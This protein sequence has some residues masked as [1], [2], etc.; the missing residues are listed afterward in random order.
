MINLEQGAEE[1]EVE[2]KQISIREGKRKI[3]RNVNTELI[4]KIFR[5]LIIDDRD[6][7][8]PYYGP[9]YYRVMARAH[10]TEEYGTIVVKGFIG[11]YIMFNK[12]LVI[13]LESHAQYLYIEL[14]KGASWRDP[15]TYNGTVVMGRAKIRLPSPTSLRAISGV[16][17]LVGLNSDRCVVKKGVLEYSMKLHRYV[18][19]V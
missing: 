12:E 1:Q 16:V 14:V 10:E 15:G 7:L 18:Q 8:E 17:E 19:E 3:D 4:V 5:A 9:S 11:R 2:K 13:P 6:L